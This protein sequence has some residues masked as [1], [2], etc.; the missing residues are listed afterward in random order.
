MNLTRTN[1]GNIKI[2]NDGCDNYENKITYHIIARIFHPVMKTR[3]EVVHSFSIHSTPETDSQ[4]EESYYK[5]VVEFAKK[6][7][8]SEEYFNLYNIEFNL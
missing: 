2:E 7:R 4:H 8:D 6:T 3:S 5:E 1:L